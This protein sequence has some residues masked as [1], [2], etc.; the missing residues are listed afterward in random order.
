MKMLPSLRPE[1]TWT[2]VDGVGIYARAWLGRTPRPTVVLIHGLLVSGRYMVP[3]AKQLAPDFDVWAIDMPGFGRSDNPKG[4]PDVPALASW[5]ERWLEHR[6]LRD[7]TL[8]ANSFGCQ[9]S[10]NLAARNSGRIKNLVLTGPTIDRI[11]RN[12]IT[13]ATRFAINIPREP[14]SLILVAL[15]DLLDFSLRR[16]ALTY[17]H[18][19][20]HHIEEDL[21]RIEC[22]TVI[23]CGERDPLVPRRWA[24]E[25]THLLPDGRL[26][27]LRDAPHAINYN[28]PEAVARI[29]RDTVRNQRND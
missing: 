22:L 20:R 18:A 25:T 5:L 15:R 3:L 2:T 8:V 29:V 19:L 6:D 10:A 11:G 1:T 27:V 21:P 28:S 9:Y 17:G 26:E 23:A 4:I 13:Q 7:V 24:E 14:V 16:L 12:A